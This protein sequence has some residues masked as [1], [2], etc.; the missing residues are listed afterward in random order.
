[1]GENI[2]NIAMKRGKEFLQINIK[3]GNPTIRGYTGN[4]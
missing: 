2:C 1:M 3:M 4:S